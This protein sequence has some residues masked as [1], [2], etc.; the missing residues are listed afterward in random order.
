MV[1]NGISNLM[2]YIFFVTLV[3][4]LS[5]SFIKVDCFAQTGSFN[6]RFGVFTFSSSSQVYFFDLPD[7]HIR[8]GTFNYGDS[9]VLSRSYLSY[10]TTSYDY[11]YPSGT[12]VYY[13]ASQDLFF[14]TVYHLNDQGVVVRTQK[15][16][17][18]LNSSGVLSS[19]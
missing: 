17:D 18:D 2:K 15:L 5:F 19:K 3:S 14:D 16:I 6:S 11:V 12:T 9:I 13:D 8:I 1:K 4:L 7:G 10:L